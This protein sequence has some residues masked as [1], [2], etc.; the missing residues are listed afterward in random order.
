M[1]ESAKKNRVPED[2]MMDILIALPIKSILRFRC[3]SK[4]W[5]SLITDKDFINAY[6][7]QAKPLLLL[8]R[9]QDRQE[10]YSLHLDNESLDRSL[11]FQN[12]P[13]RSEADCFD[14]IGSC[15][16]VVCLSD[17]DH[18]GRTKSLILWNPTIRK[19]LNLPLPKLCGPHSAT[20]GFGFDLSSD[21]YRVVRVVRQ[22]SSKREFPMEFQVAFNGILHWLVYREENDNRRHSFVLS[23]DLSNDEFGEIMLPQRLARVDI[24]WM[25]IS[26]LDD[27]LAA[28]FYRRDAKSVD[29]WFMREYGVRNSWDRLYRIQV[30]GFTRGMV[31]RKNGEI[32]MTKHGSDEVVSCNP[33]TQASRNFGNLRRCDHAE[34]FVQSLSL[35]NESNEIDSRGKKKQQ[36]GNVKLNS[37]SL[38]EEQVMEPGGGAGS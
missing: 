4:S 3:L 16:G 27:S 38:G 34:Y 14:I 23:F 5:N 22:V 36:K 12:L 33:R 24:F 21:D 2:V 13:F 9:W 25:V 19:H 30:D 8:R 11:Q 17:I 18:H 32:L 1:T 35:L 29:V 6:L 37:R 26:E 10:L 28:L 20:W 31:F 15:N 7:A